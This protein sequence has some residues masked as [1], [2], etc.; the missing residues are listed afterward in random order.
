MNN[1]K[2]ELNF[3]TPNT[4]IGKEYINLYIGN[5]L[6]GILTNDLGVIRLEN[7]EIVLKTILDITHPLKTAM[8]LLGRIAEALIVK[9]CRESEMT[10]RKWLSRARTKRVFRATSLKFKAIGTGLKFTKEF[11]S[12]FYNP[13]DTQ[14]DIIWIDESNNCAMI[15]DRSNQ[16]A[17]VVAGLQ[18]KVSTDYHTILRDILNLKYEIPIVYFDIN[19]DFEKLFNDLNEKYKTFLLKHSIEIGKDIISAHILDPNIFYELLQYYELVV[20]IVNGK[21]KPS[22]LIDFS[23]TNDI[24]K[25]AVI[26]TSLNNINITTDSINTN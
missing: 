15:P 22:E 26:S 4:L 7:N 18:I 5:N 24:L 8:T 20:A 23:K 6:L 12:T 17:G 3:N 11:Y 9:H 13:N 14:R 16:T 1:L 19:N 2:V 25:N 21:L 10:N